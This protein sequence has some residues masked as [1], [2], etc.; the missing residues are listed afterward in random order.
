MP[1]GDNFDK[2]Y[3]FVIKPTVEEEGITCWRG[4]EIKKCIDFVEDVTSH[5]KKAQFIIA[6]ISG[7][8]PNVFLEIGM[9][10][11]LRKRIILISRDADAPFNARTLRRINYEDNSKGWVQLS[12]EIRE[13]TRRLKED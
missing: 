10:L 7:G 12:D 5:I 6:D 8:N 13:N 9:C 2:L 3:S 11:Q 4:D 1:F